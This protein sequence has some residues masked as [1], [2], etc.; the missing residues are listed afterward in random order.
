[1]SAPASRQKILEFDSPYQGRMPY[2]LWLPPGDE[3][4][5]PL[6]IFLHGA[7]ERGDDPTAV[8]CYGPPRMVEEGTDFPFILASPQ[9]REGG[10]WITQD[11]K[12]F[13]ERLCRDHPIDRERIYLTGLSMGG[14]GTWNLSMEHPEIFAAIAP[15]CGGGDSIRFILLP[16]EK[17]A[18][19]KSLP[20]RA[21]HGDSDMV[22]PIQESLRMVEIFRAA[23]NENVE[24][25]VYPGVAH[26]SW[27]HAY[28]TPGLIEWFLSHRRSNVFS[29]HP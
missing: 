13:V 2:L 11:L 3:S 8:A 16:E 22:V 15:V 18:A 23:G 12:A 19:L 24:L 9:C 21:F 7:G 20:V 25:T 4:R 1:M 5:V 29:G 26:N 10:N 27:D 28:A 14:Y 6:M 17:R